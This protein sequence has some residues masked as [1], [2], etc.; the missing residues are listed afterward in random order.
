MKKLLVVFLGLFAFAFSNASTETNININSSYEQADILKTTKLIIQANDLFDIG[1]QNTSITIYNII[2]QEVF[3]KIIS[4]KNN[5]VNV[6][7][8]KNGLY[9]LKHYTTDDIIWYRFIKTNKQTDTLKFFIHDKTLI[10]SH[11]FVY[12]SPLQFQAINKEKIKSYKYKKLTKQ[13]FKKTN[14]N[15]STNNNRYV[16]V[17][18]FV[19]PF[20]KNW[21]LNQYKV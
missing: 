3:S 1:S 13:G 21:S 11:I 4:T 10:H 9:L 7:H 15:I 8:L 5:S 20:Q 18:V 17:L 2:G 19:K 16:E 14:S 12:N 6:S